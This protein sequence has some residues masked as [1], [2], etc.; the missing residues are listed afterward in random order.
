M[1]ELRHDKGS[2]FEQRLLQ[3]AHSIADYGDIL[4]VGDHYFSDS[5]DDQDL[6]QYCS[7][8]AKACAGS[9]LGSTAPSLLDL[10]IATDPEI[11]P[12]GAKDVLLSCPRYLLRLP[13][14]DKREPLDT[15]SFEECPN[16]PQTHE[17]LWGN[18]AFLCA[19]VLIRNQLKQEE[20]RFYFDDIPA[21]SF[22]QDGEPRLQPGTE[23]VLTENQ[24]NALLSQGIIALIGF[25]RRPGVRLAI[26]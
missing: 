26:F 25:H 3:H 12:V 8:L 4:L 24:I 17:L 5:E 11:K 14:G 9:Y 13:Y 6:M 20:A 10:A 18:P 1:A 23:R 15:F 21:F 2:A 22:E 7:R 19:R 16:L